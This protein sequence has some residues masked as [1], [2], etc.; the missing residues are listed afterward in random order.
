MLAARPLLLRRSVELVLVILLAV[1]G[2]RLIWLLI[3]PGSEP[4]PAAVASLVVQPVDASV[5][6]RFDAFFH[7]GGA[8]LE[9]DEASP[10]QMHLFGLRSDG[11]GGGSAI[12]GMADGRQISV[13]VGESVEPGVILQAVGPDFVTLSRDGSLSRLQFTEVPPDAAPP[14]P[15]PPG[16][17][18]VTPAPTTAAPAGTPASTVPTVDPSR[19]IAQAS[20]RP[21]MS[22][23]RIKGFTL[24]ARGDGAALRAAGLQ[25]GDVILAVNG[26]EL[27][28]LD[29]VAGLRADLANASMAEIRFERA[30][31]VQTTTIRTG[32]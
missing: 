21:R 28:S 31:Q 11:V 30:G 32:N 14:P 18:I 27:N 24:G 26:T 25:S 16:P 23:L 10:D 20:L 12:I 22:G 5:F 8:S 6:E 19:L 29:R 2:S 15:P 17:Q 7:T 13:G 1:Q 4:S 9:G 3:D